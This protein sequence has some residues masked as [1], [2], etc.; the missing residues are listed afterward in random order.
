[1][2]L[3]LDTDLAFPSAQE[4]E[5]Y[6]AAFANSVAAVLAITPEFVSVRLQSSTSASA[7][8]RGLRS[9]PLLLVLA[10]IA[11]STE[12]KA[13]AMVNA[14]ASNGSGSGDFTT[15]LAN[16]L[17]AD[18]SI[19]VLK[20]KLRADVISH[21]KAD[22]TLIALLPSPTTC[23]DGQEFRASSGNCQPCPE[24]TAGFDGQCNVCIEGRV[25]SEERTEC[26]DDPEDAAKWLITMAIAM[27]SALVV[28]CA[29]LYGWFKK[30]KQNVAVWEWEDDD[31]G[32]ENWKSFDPTSTRTLENSHQHARCE[33]LENASIQITMKGG[34]TYAVN[35][36]T[37][38]QTNVRTNFVRR[39]KRCEKANAAKD[40]T[41]FPNNW[42]AQD[43]EDANRDYAWWQ[44]CTL[45]D[46]PKYQPEW[47][48]VLSALKESLP[49]AELLKLQRCQIR[50]LWRSY[51]NRRELIHLKSG[52]ATTNEKLAWHI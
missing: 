42:V 19:E 26:I 33:G 8:G 4:H 17:L 47:Q 2:T 5:T 48:Q 38:E 30:S 40:I 34:Q 44:K 18:H 3:R 23:A 20:S 50:H 27:P 12:A 16:S 29:A 41:A 13:D 1:L 28:I 36:A 45:V 6:K 22:G 10:T 25:A 11:A 32:S 21:K 43:D 49:N 7:G 35:Y 52:N 46:V 14:I 24:N 9:G 39:I 37:M 15:A 51:K 31:C